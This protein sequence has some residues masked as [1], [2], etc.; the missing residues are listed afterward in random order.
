MGDRNRGVYQKFLVE[1]TDG[2]SAPGQ[3]HHNC[4]YFVLDCDHDPHAKAALEA[5]ARSCKHEYPTLASDVQA[6]V[7]GCAFGSGE[8]KHVSDVLTIPPYSSKETGTAPEPPEKTWDCSICG[9]SNYVTVTHCEHCEYSRMVLH[10]GRLVP[11]DGY[12]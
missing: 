3:K 7:Q 9:R 11:R 2:K 5:Y 4:F 6:I 10:A 1:R 12:R 8:D